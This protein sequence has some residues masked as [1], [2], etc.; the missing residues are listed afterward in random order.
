MY[1]GELTFTPVAGK[2]VFKPEIW[3]VYLGQKWNSA[4]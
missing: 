3:D 4:K 1:F 2:C